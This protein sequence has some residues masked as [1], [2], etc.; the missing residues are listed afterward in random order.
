VENPGT[1]GPRCSFW[2][3]VHHQQHDRHFPIAITP[4]LYIPVDPA[5]DQSNQFFIHPRSVCVMSRPLK[6]SSTIAVRS[7]KRQVAK[8]SMDVSWLIERL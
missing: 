2:E 7:E 8:A 4:A 5:S 3:S 6:A 1:K